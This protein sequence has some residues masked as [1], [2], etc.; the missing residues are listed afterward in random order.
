MRNSKNECLLYIIYC[1][2]GHLALKSM[3][4]WAMMSAV[5]H[6]TISM[7]LGPTY[8]SWSYTQYEYGKVA[9]RRR[10]SYKT[11]QLF[12]DNGSS[13]FGL[14]RE[15]HRWAIFNFDIEVSN[16]FAAFFTFNFKLEIDAIIMNFSLYNRGRFR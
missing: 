4:A 12:Y 1:F 6:V 16:C 3:V 9:N 10:K 15:T 8:F 7:E 2:F 13:E 5:A 14:A 11:A